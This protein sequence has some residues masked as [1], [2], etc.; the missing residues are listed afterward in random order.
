[1]EVVANKLINKKVSWP[2]F[3]GRLTIFML[4]LGVPTYLFFTNFYVSFDPQNEKSAG[5][6]F[7]IIDRND[8]VL[9]KGELYAFS[10]ERLEPLFKDGTKMVK[11]LRAV[12]G[13]TVEVTTGNVFVNGKAITGGP[14]NAPKLKKKLEDFVNKGVLKE[15]QFW[16]LG[17]SPSSFDSRYWGAVSERQILGRAYGIF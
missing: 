6:S 5:Y 17:V 2:A 4:A 15:D 3:F 1:M 8:R 9:E 7:F 10:A 12:P 11:F 14:L 16:F 13:D